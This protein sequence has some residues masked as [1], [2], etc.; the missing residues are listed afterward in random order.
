MISSSALDIN[1]SGTHHFDN[2]V[3]YKMNFRLQQLI[4]HRKETEF[5]IIEDD[6]SGMRIFMSMK[7]TTENPVFSMDKTT[8]KSYRKDKWKKESE[9]ISSIL[10][11]EIQTIFGKNKE[12]KTY[13]A[14][15]KPL[16]FE[17]E[18]DD[19]TDTTKIKITR[20]SLANKNDTLKVKPKNFILE[21][22]EDIRNSD[23]D[24]Y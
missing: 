10:N 4:K 23:D 7:G 15:D 19:E 18:W 1:I 5:G 11:K 21:S 16:K 20:D 2:R 14:T 9:N 17:L 8:K 12:N 24:D 3:E 6:G 22:D 13:D